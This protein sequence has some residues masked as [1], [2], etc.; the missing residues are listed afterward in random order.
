MANIFNSLKRQLWRWFENLEEQETGGFSFQENSMPP[1]RS[2]FKEQSHRQAITELLNYKAYD[3]LRKLYHQEDGVGFAI[4]ASP[5]TGMSQDDLRTLEGIL[6]SNYRSGTILQFTLYAD[7]NIDHIVDRW[8]ADRGKDKEIRNPEL[9]RQLAKRRTDYL[10]KASWQ[11]LWKDEY[12]LVRD[13]H[14]IIS[15]VVP[16]A[17]GEESLSRSDMDELE[18][19]RDSMLGILRSARLSG[20]ILGPQQLIDLVG[21][22]FRPKLIS[23][24]KRETVAYRPQ[25]NLGQQI[26]PDETAL[27]VGRDSLTIDWRGQIISVLPYAIKQFPPHWC[28]SLNGE[29]IG[30]FFNR[31][32]RLACPYLIT[33]LVVTTDQTLAKGSAKTKYLRA[34]QM[35]D[36]PIGKYVPAWN[37][38]YQDWKYVNAKL[39]QGS[40]LL[41]VA[42]HINLFSPV[43]EEEAA[44]QSLKNILSSLGWRDVK[45][46]FSALPCFL[47]SLPLAMGR[48]AY[49]ICDRLKFFRTML[50]WNCINIAP[51]VGEW[52]GNVPISEQPMLMFLGRRGQLCFVDPFQ[53]DKGNYNIAVAAASGAGKSFFTQEYL[54]AFLAAGGRG[55]VIDSGRSYQ[56]MCELLGGTFIDFSKMSKVILNPF[57]T[58]IEKD[59]VSDAVWWETPNGFEDQ[60]VLLTELI[61]SMADPLNP[62]PSKHKALLQMAI[63]RAWESKKKQASITTVGDML[64]QM[65]HSEAKDISVM[66]SPYMRGGAFAEYFEGTANI[67]FSSSLIVLELDDLNAK[68]D[69]QTVVVF[70]LMKRITEVMYLSGR[71]QKKICII[72]EAWRFLGTGNASK[73]IEEGYRTARKYNGSFMT[74][75]QGIPDYYKSATA[76][77][78]YTNSDFAFFMRQKPESLM[79]AK[80]KNYLIMNEWEEITY[81]SITT[82]GK[83]KHHPGGKYSEIAMKTPDGMA[84]GLLCVDPMSARLM[85]TNAK[86]VE[87]IRNL[88]RLGYG[89]WEAIETVAGVI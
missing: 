84:V 54:Q 89:K 38:R 62:L 3:P 16:L 77:A 15:C 39:E 11:G 57:S 47:S 1:R 72:D 37:D 13:Y 67:D 60:I 20:D 70:L 55:F 78:A 51:L 22:L 33:L 66:L 9:Y 34:T 56:N 42:Y 69:L 21:D 30:P 81:A 27:Y 87:E 71:S 59:D 36:T 29:V 85:S 83:S 17:R 7:P 4:Y 8:A 63:M 68:G 58:I 10:K 53:N 44:E 73:M 82:F 19:H 40:R 48:E 23:E 52:K 76:T 6:K 86:D 88:E 45:C 28:G 79:E 75:T 43:G 26:V 31:Y 65:E 49:L 25:Q 24:E 35:K 46:R 14:I 80:N 74:V 2:F 18:R 32:Q 12:L 61:S 50:S 41:K 64:A 5:A